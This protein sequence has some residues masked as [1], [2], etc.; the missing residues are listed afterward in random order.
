[1]AEDWKILIWIGVVVVD[2]YILLKTD[3]NNYK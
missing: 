2:L 1:M 3:L